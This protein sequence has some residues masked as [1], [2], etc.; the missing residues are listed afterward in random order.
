M[1][2]WRILAIENDPSDFWGIKREMLRLA[3][4][5]LFDLATTF[6]DAQELLLMYTYDVVIAD[7]EIPVT[8]ELA[9]LIAARRVPV[10][11]LSQDG[12]PVS[13]A[14]MPIACVVN[15]RHPEKASSEA[16]SLLRHMGLLHLKHSSKKVL[17][18][19]FRALSKLIPREA[20]DMNSYK[21]FL[22]Y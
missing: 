21:A 13:R 9:E 11:A 4:G 12:L 10:V 6:E 3:P 2:H 14:A 7:F 1:K 5:C 18:R 15:P 22:F 17:M 16:V 20:P 8:F 19:L